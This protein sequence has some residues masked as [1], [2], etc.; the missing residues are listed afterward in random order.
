MPSPSKST[1]SGS[2]RPRKRA[3]GNHNGVRMQFDSSAQT[4][5]PAISSSSSN[6]RP[7]S[8]YFAGSG[9]AASS[10]APAPIVASPSVAHGN[11]YMS[12]HFGTSPPSSSAYLHSLV[13]P[14][15]S[16]PASEAHSSIP[17][18][19]LGQSW[20]HSLRSPFQS[21][22]RSN[23]HLTAAGLSHGFPPTQIPSNGVS[24]FEQ[25]AERPLRF[26]TPATPDTLSNQK[27]FRRFALSTNSATGTP[28]LSR[29]SSR[30]QTP[31]DPTLSPLWSSTATVPEDPLLVQHAH[32]MSPPLSTL[33]IDPSDSFRPT[34]DEICAP[35]K[36]LSHADQKL[37]ILQILRNA[38]ISPLEFLTDLT[39]VE[40]SDG[41]TFRSQWYQT[42]S[43]SLPHLFDTIM[44]D[45]A[46]A[47]K[48]RAWATTHFGNLFDL[49]LE[50]EIETVCDSLSTPDGLKGITPEF[51][52]AWSASST[53]HPLVPLCPIIS[54]AITRCAQ[55]DR[56]KVKNKN[57]KPDTVCTCFNTALSHWVANYSFFVSALCSCNLTNCAPTIRRQD[58]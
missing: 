22:M 18:S 36:G 42:E 53:L 51:I 25:Q 57:K 19:L 12:E 58:S 15:N 43:K 9:G 40:N 47:N 52:E 20:Y 44:D 32:D 54:H 16:S 10:P 27:R 38:R 6:T 13:H 29:A 17:S 49:I 39:D 8:E 1:I 55:T 7:F 4:H 5:F 3:K 37:A 34:L 2:S 41:A 33:P 23:D 45:H 14:P 31:I 56:A 50:K 48:L 30:S 35:F 11:F 26:Q 46:G 21:A 24:P 28:P